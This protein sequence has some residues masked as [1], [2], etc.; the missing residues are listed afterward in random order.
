MTTKN[1]FTLYAILILLYGI[2]FLFLPSHVYDLY[3]LADQS[4]PLATNLLG[5]LGG[6]FIAAGIMAWL[7]KDSG[8]SACRKAII[9][10]ITVS[11]LIFLIRNIMGLAAGAGMGTMSYVDLIVQA[12]FTI[13]GIYLLTKE[14]GGAS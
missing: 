6:V 7:S 5:G 2:C 8:P 4:S 10:F 13:C 9:I 14:K 12:I 3:G 11:S 1:Y